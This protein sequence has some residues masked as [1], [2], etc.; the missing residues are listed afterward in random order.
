M[1]KERVHCFISGR[2]QGVRFRAYTKKSAER[3]GLKGWVKNLND[4]RVETLAEGEEEK[5]NKFIKLLEKGSMLS[6]VDEVKVN[7]EGYVGSFSA[8]RIVY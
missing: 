4:G 6:K 3:L 5:L 2:V 8:F 7:E 1:A